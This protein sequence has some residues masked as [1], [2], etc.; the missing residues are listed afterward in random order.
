MFRYGTAGLLGLALSGPAV[1][2]DIPSDVTTL[3]SLFQGVRHERSSPIPSEARSLSGDR[4]WPEAAAE[5]D[6]R[7]HSDA[8]VGYRRTLFRLGAAS[9]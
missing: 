9:V 2:G 4:A 1:A 8:R 7:S 3:M 5:D 6:G